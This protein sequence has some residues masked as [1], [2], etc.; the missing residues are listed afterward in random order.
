MLSL[1]DQV[2][3][4]QRTP[5]RGHFGGMY[6]AIFPCASSQ[7]V[8]SIGGNRPPHPSHPRGYEEG[9]L[10]DEN[11]IGSITIVNA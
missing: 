5:P 7:W 4:A 11:L 1:L 6:S 9:K 10:S 3:R 2:A 8:L